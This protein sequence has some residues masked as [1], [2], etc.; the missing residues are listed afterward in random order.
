MGKRVEGEKEVVKGVRKGRGK[1]GG[2]GGKRRDRKCLHK[3]SLSYGRLQSY[4]NSC[5]GVLQFFKDRPTYKQIPVRTIPALYSTA[6]V[7]E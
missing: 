5:S 7:K 3:V 4:I 1:N 2:N 6:A